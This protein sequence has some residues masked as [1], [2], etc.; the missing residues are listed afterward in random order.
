[1]DLHIDDFYR[2]AALGLV[3]LYQ[4]FPRP[5]TLYLD[6]LV[7]IL[8]PDEVGLP[9]PRQLQCLNTLLWLGN[10]G[11]LRHLGTI[12]YSAVD[13]AE[14]TEKAFLRLSSSQHPF[15]AGLDEAPSSIRR[16]QGSLAQQ[17]RQPLRSGDTE[18]VIR[19]MQHFF[20]M[21]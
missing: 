9:H 11:Y 13:Q 20:Q 6:D 8:P 5:V 19:V 4:S 16:A 14:L 21:P 12:G 7:G 18:V 3:M 10:E 17:L 2:D 1:M 15:A